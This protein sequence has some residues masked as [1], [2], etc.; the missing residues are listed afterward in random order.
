[1]FANFQDFSVNACKPLECIMRLLLLRFEL[2][3][4]PF[5]LELAAVVA[6]R[7]WRLEHMRGQLTICSTE[8]LFPISFWCISLFCK[9]LPVEIVADF[10]PIYFS[11]LSYGMD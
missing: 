10:S 6:R 2:P 9:Q 11:M 7:C 4:L 8:C 3:S 1:M 5:T